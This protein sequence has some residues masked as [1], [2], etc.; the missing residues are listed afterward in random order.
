MQLEGVDGSTLPVKHYKC[1]NVYA[2][3]IF[4]PK[5]VIVVGKIHRHSHLNIISQGAVQVVTEFGYNRYVAPFTFVSEVG[6]KRVVCA[7]ADTIWTTIHESDKNTLEEIEEMTIAKTY[8]DVP[9]LPENLQKM[10]G[11]V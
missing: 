4:I 2:R 8:Q 1:G 9:G 7:D 10:I 11:E 5:G 3:E 6:T